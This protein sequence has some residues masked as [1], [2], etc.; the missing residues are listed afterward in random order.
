TSGAGA[1]RG[2]A[3]DVGG[4]GGCS[5]GL[6]E[7]ERGAARRF[8]EDDRMHEVCRMLRSSTNLFLKVDR[9]AEASELDHRHKLQMR[10]LVLCRR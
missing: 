9:A 5:D 1:A 6:G 10:L 7:V 4:A 3:G 8:P 2:G